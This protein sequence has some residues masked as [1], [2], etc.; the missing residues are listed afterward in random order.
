MIFRWAEGLWSESFHQ[1]SSQT[2]NFRYPQNPIEPL[3]LRFFFYVCF[4]IFTSTCRTPPI[5]LLTDSAE[6][7]Q[8]F[9]YV[10]HTSPM[11]FRWAEGL[12]SESFRQKS[13]Q[14][15]NFRHPQ[16]PFEPLFLSFFYVCFN[17]F[18]ST[19]RT[20]PIFFYWRIALSS[21][22]VFH[23][24]NIPLRQF[25]DELEGFEVKVSA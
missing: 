20:S 17:I 8:C 3:F 18:T 7:R 15:Q 6:F 5:F 1:K 24:Q 14:T 9:K 10:K 16:N 4:N 2:Q 25:F 21:D 11:S 23:M 22:N 12:W 13:S 19:C